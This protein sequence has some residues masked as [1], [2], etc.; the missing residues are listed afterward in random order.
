MDGAMHT[1]PVLQALVLA[2]QVYTDAVTKKK[3]IAGTF[4]HLWA[5]EFPTTFERKTYA[6]ICVTEVYGKV[7]IVLRY[8]DLYSNEVLMESPRVE[9]RAD[10]PTESVEMVFPVPP[11]PM[12][13]EGVFAFEV[14]AGGEVL[15]SL[16]IKASKIPDRSKP[17]D[18]G[19]Q[20]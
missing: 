4:N 9:V 19:E 6:F 12:P 14:H 15:G 2:D 5:G 7:P 11:F 3:I 18:E 8:V 1:K 16:R 10:D 13:R 17:S 20:K